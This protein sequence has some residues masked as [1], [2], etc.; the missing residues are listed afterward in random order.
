MNTSLMHLDRSSSI[1][2]ILTASSLKKKVTLWLV[3]NEVPSELTM[4]FSVSTFKETYY[5][6]LF[7]MNL[8]S[9]HNGW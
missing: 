6:D 4:T 1:I 5:Y 2:A 9:F 7:Q 3:Y 8:E